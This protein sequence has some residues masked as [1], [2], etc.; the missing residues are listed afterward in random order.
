VAKH[1][2][3]TPQAIGHCSRTVISRKNKVSTNMIKK[4]TLSIA[5]LVLKLR[6][7][8]FVDSCL[9]SFSNC[10]GN[11]SLKKLLFKAL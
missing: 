3:I 9:N 7:A 10:L 5:E 1:R 11:K 2:K 4:A 8:V 6:A